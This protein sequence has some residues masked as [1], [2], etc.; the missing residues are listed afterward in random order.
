MR[1]LLL[2]HEHLAYASKPNQASAE[3]SAVAEENLSEGGYHVYTASSAADLPRCIHEV[4][5]AVVHLPIAKIAGWQRNLEK[6]RPVPMLWWCSPY[7]GT[8]SADYCQDDAP[9]DGI[10]TPSMSPS[11]LHWALHVGAK[12]FLDRQQWHTERQ[13]LRSKLEERKWIDMAKGILSDINRISEAEAYDMLRRKAM[14]ERKRIVD[15]A[16]SIVKAHQ[17]LKA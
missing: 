13:Q 12:Q 17:Q 3:A 1:R 7:S 10:L 14:N 5:A 2:I 4:D 11:E 8:S 15:V 16:T 9:I 6:L